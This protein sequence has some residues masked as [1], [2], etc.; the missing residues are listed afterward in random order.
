MPLVTVGCRERVRVDGRGA[1]LK[2][3]SFMKWEA[4]SN[5]KS[6]VNSLEHGGGVQPVRE[7]EGC[8]V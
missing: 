3:F 4:I 1:V 6:T 2:I 5:Q 8:E 7:V